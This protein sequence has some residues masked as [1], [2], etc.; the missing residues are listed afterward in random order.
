[1]DFLN[2]EKGVIPT[3]VMTEKTNARPIGDSTLTSEVF[4]NLRV[5]PKAFY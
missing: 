2:N 5:S 1:M 4:N 3:S